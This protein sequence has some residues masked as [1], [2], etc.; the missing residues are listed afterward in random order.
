MKTVSR[1]LAVFAVVVFLAPLTRA[2]DDTPNINKRGESEKIFADKLSSAIVRA[3]RTATKT[4]VLE[5]F[6]KKTPKEGRL[7]YHIK[8]GWKSAVLGKNQVSEIVVL[9]DT[10]DKDKWEVLRIEYS[11]DAKSAAPYNRKNVSELVKKL[12]GK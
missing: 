3:A 7:E 6:E 12:N 10:T 9:I 2:D 5:S 4:A 1:S 11:D 8:A